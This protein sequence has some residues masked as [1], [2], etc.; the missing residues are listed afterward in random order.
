VNAQQ[1]SRCKSTDHQ[2]TISGR[3]RMLIW[4]VVVAKVKVT[5]A[6]IV[7]DGREIF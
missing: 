3:A 2:T 7:N 1:V 6:S 5:T 4:W